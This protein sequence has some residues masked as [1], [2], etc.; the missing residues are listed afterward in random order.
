MYKGANVTKRFKN[1]KQI[2]LQQKYHIGT[3]IM[4]ES[5]VSTVPTGHGNSS[6]FD[7]SILKPC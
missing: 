1:T 6:A 2:E 4:H 3:L 7:F 5:F